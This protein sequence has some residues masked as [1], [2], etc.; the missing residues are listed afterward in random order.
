[1]N[2]TSINC[3]PHDSWAGWPRPDDPGLNI[4]TGI[5][6]GFLS[7]DIVSSSEKFIWEDHFKLKHVSVTYRIWDIASKFG[8]PQKGMKK[9]ERLQSPIDGK[10]EVLYR[11][12]SATVPFPIHVGYDPYLTWVEKVAKDIA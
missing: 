9:A 6:N 4:L 3:F 5:V 12:I 7:R 1:M 2:L 10:R 11:D 8:K